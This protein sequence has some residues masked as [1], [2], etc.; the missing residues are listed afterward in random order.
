MECSSDYF[1]CMADSYVGKPG[2]NWGF[3]DYHAESY[4]FAKTEESKIKE[5]VLASERVLYAIEKACLDN[6]SDRKKLEKRAREIVDEIAHTFSLKTI[7]F[8]SFMLSKI[9]N[10]LFRNVYV[11][12][13]GIEK[14][15]HAAKFAPLVFVPS[16]NSYFDF[17]LTSLVCFAVNLPLPAIASGQDFLHIAVVN[18]LLRGSGAFFLRRS[19]ATDHFYKSIFTEYVQQLVKDGRMPIEF[20]LEG[21]RSRSGK[22]LHA[23]KG[24]MS[25]ITEM[26]FLGYVPDI[27]FCPISISYECI[28]EESLYLFEL[29]GIP[30]P[31]ESLSGLVKARKVLSVDYGTAYL[32]FGDVFS[33]K[34]F[35]SGS[36]NRAEYAL[37]PRHHA[38]LHPLVNRKQE[39]QFVGT[40]S[41]FL[42]NQQQL[43]MAIFPR[44]IVAAGV[45][46]SIDNLDDLQILVTSVGGLLKHFKKHVHG[47]NNRRTQVLI[48]EAVHFCSPVLKLDDAKRKVAVLPYDVSFTEL[49][50]TALGQALETTDKLRNTMSNVYLSLQRNKLMHILLVPSCIVTAG[51][52]GT[53]EKIE[54]S[55]LLKNYSL[56]Q[57]IL[58]PEFVRDPTTN[59]KNEVQYSLDILK[60][61]SCVETVIGKEMVYVTSCSS[62]KVLLTFLGGLVQPF[63]ETYWLAG[64]Y[65]LTAAKYP[66]EISTLAS[67]IQLYAASSLHL[68]ILRSCEAMSLLTLKN[69]ITSLMDA[70]CLIMANSSRH[71]TR[72]NGINHE[73]LHTYISFLA[74]F[75]DLS[76]VWLSP[77]ENGC[78]RI[79]ARL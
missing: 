10:K 36:I 19:F 26:F 56:L 33:L 38:D 54:F 30:K 3:K 28:T 24:M 67:E 11:N 66:C 15:S 58:R 55:K 29:L 13:S 27:L 57:K 68:G 41:E 23:K 5:N 6:S 50:R 1:N 71:N 2:L 35:C 53:E 64:Q 9:V 44:A 62:N 7:R 78:I 31:K 42:V 18:R 47:I 70:G 40:F 75:C 72:V 77:P 46:Q 48:E 32:H 43:N 79:K 65:M 51:R 73:K 14:L 34:E 74:G 20:F 60:R 59:D 21:T 16:H 12:R 39:K 61:V 69:A 52:L 4:M 49:K 8:M 22:S 25:M 37:F 63:I 17:L 76:N 45:L